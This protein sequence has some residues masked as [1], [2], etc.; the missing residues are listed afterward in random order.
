M[1]KPAESI[2]RPSPASRP[3]TSGPQSTT[4]LSKPPMRVLV[5]PSKRPPSNITTQRTSV[6]RP[7]ARQ[8]STMGSLPKPVVTMP[9][10][11]GRPT[12]GP[13]RVLVQA[14]DKPASR[15][16]SA[17]TIPASRIQGPQRVLIQTTS[18]TTNP[19]KKP[20]GLSSSI[21]PPAP[22]SRLPGPSRIA[23]PSTS[24]TTKAS[25]TSKPAGRWV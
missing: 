23:V 25:S 3:S 13:R 8:S 4:T 22:S 9:K 19:M 17:S 5:P 12:D 14:S 2:R 10:T 1:K 11:V 20:L 18:A 6:V 16:A 24:K 21:N 7:V 15:M